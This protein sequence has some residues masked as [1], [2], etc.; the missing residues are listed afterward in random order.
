M[1]P[2][3]CCNMCYRHLSDTIFSNNLDNKDPSTI[4]QCREKYK[5]NTN[6]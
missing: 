1:T 4:V 2:N 3:D 6:I 5:K